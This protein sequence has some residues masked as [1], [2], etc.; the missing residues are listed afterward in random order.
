V[1][2]QTI[3]QL[4]LASRLAESWNQGKLYLIAHNFSRQIVETLSTA[5]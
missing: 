2:D 4:L 5:I 3:I 1:R